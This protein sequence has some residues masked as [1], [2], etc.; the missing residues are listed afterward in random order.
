MT[1]EITVNGHIYTV[2]HSDHGDISVTGQV[3]TAAGSLWPNLVDGLYAAFRELDIPAGKLEHERNGALVFHFGSGLALDIA[4]KAFKAFIAEDAI[5]T[6][7]RAGA[8]TLFRRHRLAE[9]A[10]L[11]LGRGLFYRDP[12]R[13]IQRRMSERLDVLAGEFKHVYKNYM[14]AERDWT[15]WLVQ[16]HDSFQ[17][18]RR[19]PL[20]D[21]DREWLRERVADVYERIHGDVVERVSEDW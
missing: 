2:A 14:L 19:I 7:L 10:G 3:R 9:L 18:A 4:R 20:Q 8:E 13:E 6:G 16:L 11:A 5:L 21:G 1:T 17:A 12:S 15:Y